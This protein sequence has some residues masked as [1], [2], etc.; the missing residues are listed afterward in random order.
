[1]L[2]WL[3]VVTTA[4]VVCIDEVDDEVITAVVGM[5]VVVD[6]MSSEVVVVL[7]TATGVVDSEVVIVKLGVVLD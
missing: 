2:Y 3:K 7:N 5:S 1:M 6:E 4:E